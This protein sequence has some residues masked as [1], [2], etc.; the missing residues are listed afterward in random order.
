MVYE[1]GSFDAAI[2][3]AAGDDFALREELLRSYGESLRLQIDLLSRARCDGNWVMAARRL[4][5]LGA[6]FHCGEL[7]CLAG[8]AMDGAPGDPVILRELRHYAAQLAS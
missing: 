8:Q 7:V 4:E 1:T 6:S 2:A 5:R 3:A